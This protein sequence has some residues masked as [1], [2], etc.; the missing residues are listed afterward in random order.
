M[1][2]LGLLVQALIER[3]LRLAMKREQIPELRLYPEQRRS[4]RPTTE[5]V[6]RLF[7][8]VYRHVLLDDG[9]PARAGARG[10]ADRPPA[11]GGR[12]PRRARTRVPLAHVGRE[13]FSDI[14]AEMC[15]E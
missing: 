7:S 5:Q 15:G 3:E 9:Q 10:R 14:A 12:P 11:S 13:T 1:Y 2:F 8:L 4:K 6:L